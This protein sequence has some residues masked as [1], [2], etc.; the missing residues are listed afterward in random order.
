MARASRSNSVSVSSV[1]VARLSVDWIV[2]DDSYWNRRGSEEAS[3][4]EKTS[5]PAEDGP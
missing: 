2:R 1:A 5:F 4:E 3:A